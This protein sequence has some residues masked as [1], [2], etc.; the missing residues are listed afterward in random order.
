MESEL[1]DLP[2]TTTVESF[3]CPN[4]GLYLFH[5]NKETPPKKR[6]PPLIALD[7]Y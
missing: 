7:P 4:Y 1:I 6:K 2:L 5:S 3:Q